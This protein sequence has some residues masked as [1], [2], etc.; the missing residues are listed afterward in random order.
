MAVLSEL[1]LPVV[2]AQ[3]AQSA[4][5]ASMIVL[6]AIIGQSVASRLSLDKLCARKA[7]DS[8]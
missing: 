4:T 1:E 5:V 3:P 6:T 8:L 7:K 2:A